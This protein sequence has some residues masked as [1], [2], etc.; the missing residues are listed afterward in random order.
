M[1]YTLR[2]SLFSVIATTR[3]ITI[4]TC[5]YLQ[6]TCYCREGGIPRYHEKLR[7]PPTQCHLS[8]ETLW[9]MAL[10]RAMVVNNPF[11]KPLGSWQGWHCGW[12][13]SACSHWLLGWWIKP[14]ENYAR[15][16]GSFSQL[17][18]RKLT[19]N[20]K[21]MVVWKTK[22]IQ[23][24]PR[25]LLGRGTGVITMGNPSNWPCICSVSFPPNG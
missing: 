11:N 9:H 12:Y 20:L 17:H 10:S 19:W 24:P 4:T 3:T 23:P 1:G 15:Q 21:M 22:D 16:N 2:C 6:L 13:F 18:P 8:L 7:G 5:F 14:F 25:L